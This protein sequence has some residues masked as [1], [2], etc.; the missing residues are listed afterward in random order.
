MR[1][2]IIVI[3]IKQPVY[4]KV[5]TIRRVLLEKGYLIPKK[6]TPWPEHGVGIVR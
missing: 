1:Y 5:N 4:T 6:I 2:N 3:V